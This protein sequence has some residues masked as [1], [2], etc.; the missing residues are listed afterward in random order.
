V[1]DWD[2][3]ETA[4]RTCQERFGNV[5]ICIAN[6]AL[7]EE[8]DFTIG[9][10]QHYRDVIETNLVGTVNT[11]RAVAPMMRAAGSGHI[12]L[13][14]SV[15]GR[16]TYVGQPV[17]IA[18]KWG[19]VGFGRALRKELLADGIRVTLIEPGLTDTDLARSS[20]LGR[21]FLSEVNALHPDDVAR[22][23]IYALEQ[24]HNVAVNELVLQPLAQ[25]V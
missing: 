7:V 18:T 1:R 16:E 5:D 11:A 21:Q 4:A 13:L 19:I 17:Y 2:Q 23:V 22:A 14:A 6:A 3:V 15:S 9:D 24:P 12:V 25:G 10:P 8:G 20:P